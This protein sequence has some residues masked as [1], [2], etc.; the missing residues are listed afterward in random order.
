MSYW[1]QSETVAFTR[2]RVVLACIV[3]QMGML[4]C[5]EIDNYTY[6]RLRA[7]RV[8]GSRGAEPH[9]VCQTT[10]VAMST[11]FMNLPCR[12]SRATGPVTRVP[13]GPDRSRFMSTQAFS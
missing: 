12:S 11:T 4:K 3:Y 10:R 1:I 2:S 8:S 13:I 7:V 6:G 5:V 9:R